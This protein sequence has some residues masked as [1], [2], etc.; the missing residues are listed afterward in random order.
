[1]TTEGVDPYLHALEAK[2]HNIPDA[3]RPT[4]D[5]C[6]ECGSGI[7]NGEHIAN[8]ECSRRRPTSE[9]AADVRSAF[10]KLRSAGRT[11][12]V[13]KT[14][15]DDGVGAL[16]A[17]VASVTDLEARE[18]AAM[19]IAEDWKRQY[20]AAEAQVAALAK[21]RDECERQYQSKVNKVIEQM[22]RAEAAEAALADR[23]SELATATTTAEFAIRKLEDTEAALATTRQALTQLLGSSDP[24]VREVA[25]RALAATE[26][27]A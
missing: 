10:E 8:Y 5:I 27:P 20:N 22:N 4:S 17:L 18:E 1:M 23:E 25:R 13:L 9:L 15:C 6:P 11:S 12:D 2:G 7:L 24:G 21:E 16:D 3:P 19:F 26:E 14:W